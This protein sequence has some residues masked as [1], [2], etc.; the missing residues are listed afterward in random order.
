MSKT[1]AK[2]AK[3][4]TDIVVEKRKPPV[5]YKNSPINP[6]NQY[7]F[8][9]DNEKTAFTRKALGEI[10]EYWDVPKVQSTEEAIQRTKEYFERCA[11][12]GIK[13]LVEEYAFALGISRATLWDWETGRRN[14]PID[15]DVIKRAKEAIA[16]FDARLVTEGKLNP[17]TYIFRGKNYYGLKDQQDVVVTPNTIEARP[18]AELI[19]EA[20]L[21]PDDEG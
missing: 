6:E 16:M 19:A 9:D 8:E 13:P 2:Q 4:I 18:R 14:G 7:L 5:G 10:M 1:P 15:A 17:V 12:K 20:A 11:I 21:L 3:E